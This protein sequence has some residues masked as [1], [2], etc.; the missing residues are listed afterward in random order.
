MKYIIFVLQVSLFASCTDQETKKESQ[1]AVLSKLPA[2]KDSVMDQQ[3]IGPAQASKPGSTNTQSQPFF[4]SVARKEDLSIDQIK[5]HTQIDSSLYT[6]PYRNARFTG[7]TVFKTSNGYKAVVLKYF[8]G[9]ATVNKYLL[10]Y[11]PEGTVTK[12]NKMIATDSDREGMEAYERNEYQFFT[13]TTFELFEYDIPKGS[14]KGTKKK[15]GRFKI[16]NYG[17]IV[18]AE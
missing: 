5:M 15:K 13:D 4:D 14:N 3:E 18:P 9:M 6:D 16:N 17:S 12:E 11:N 10:I 8:D 1:E 7:D 2:K